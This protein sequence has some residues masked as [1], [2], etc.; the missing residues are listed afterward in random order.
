M[1]ALPNAPTLYVMAQ[2]KNWGDTSM[3]ESQWIANMKQE[4]GNNWRRLVHNK[5]IQASSV[6]SGRDVDTKPTVF[7]PP[8]PPNP[9]PTP[10]PDPDPTPT[11]DPL[12]FPRGEMLGP[13]T[14]QKEEE[15]FI[16][17]YKYPLMAA[18]VIIV[19]LIVMRRNRSQT[20]VTKK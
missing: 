16:K 9:I 10:T 8:V 7:A 13:P 15:N 20:I 17:K 12:V 11:P 18:G 3:G 5:I 19:A 2:N 1:Q 14:Q 4:Y 6:H